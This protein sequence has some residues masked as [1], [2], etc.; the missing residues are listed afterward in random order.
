MPTTLINR[1][2][3]LTVEMTTKNSEKKSNKSDYEKFLEIVY[4]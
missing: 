1:N 4:H 2:S 3:D